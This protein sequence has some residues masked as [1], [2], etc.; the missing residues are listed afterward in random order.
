MPSCATIFDG[1]FIGVYDA[2]PPTDRE[3]QL[4]LD[5]VRERVSEIRCGLIVTD[6]G[7]PNAQQRKALD[8]QLKHQRGT[9]RAVVTSSAIAR[10][11]VTATSWLGH[12]LKAFSPDE[13]SLA[14][15]FLE[16]PHERRAALMAQVQKLRDELHESPG[17]SEGAQPPRGGPKGRAGKKRSAP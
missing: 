14:F 12:R 5:L 10:G 11:I 16:V 8:E 9:P 15:E 6:G 7:G 2:E 4:A 1:V 3:W 17:V 13:L